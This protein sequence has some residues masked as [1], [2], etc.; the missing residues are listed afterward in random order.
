MTQTNKS[1]NTP[2]AVTNNVDS[3]EYTIGDKTSVV[4]IGASAGGLDALERFFANVPAQT[5]LAFV[6][7]QHLSPTF[8]SLMHELLARYTNLPIYR[9][10]D[11]MK[12]EP[13]AIYLIPPGQNMLLSNGHLLLNDQD[14]AVA[15]QLPIDIFFRS[16]AHDRGPNSVAVILSG[17]GS[18]GSRGIM[19]IN[20]AGGLIVV[21]SPESA[22]FDGMPRNAIAKEVVD[23]VAAPEKMPSLIMRRL[24][25]LATDAEIDSD[26]E[27]DLSIVSSNYVDG[28]FGT[29][30]KSELIAMF[31]LLRRQY[32]IDFSVYKPAT[33]IRRIERRMVVCKK[34]SL[35]A[36]VD[37]L[38]DNVEE[39]EI[40]YRDFLVEVTEFFR[41]K[42]AY[43]HLEGTVL[44]LIRE[45]KDDEVIRV[46][47]A[48]CATGEEAYSMAI[49]FDRCRKS[50]KKEVEIQIF[51]TDVHQG[52]LALA[53]KGV[54]SAESLTEL[55]PLDLEEYFD[56]HNGNYVVKKD[57][58][59]TVI[60]SP[61]NL[62]QDPPFTRLHLVSCRNVLIYLNVTSQEKVLSRFHFGL[63]SGGILFLGASEHMAS[64]ISEDF[65]TINS[66]WRI[67]RKERDSSRLYKQQSFN[68]SDIR[69][70]MA[71]RR[72]DRSRLEAR[73]DIYEALLEGSIPASLL[74]DDKAML[75]R[76]FGNANKY[77][78]MTGEASLNVLDII[79]SSL[80]VALRS[81]LHRAAIDKKVITYHDLRWKARTSEEE[82]VQL[83]IQPIETKSATGISFLISFL[84]NAPRDNSPRDN[85]SRDNAL[86]E[87][88]SAHHRQSLSPEPSPEIQKVQAD[89]KVTAPHEGDE[90]SDSIVTMPEDGGIEVEFLPTE[91]AA[92]HIS[93]LEQELQYTHEYLHTTV[94]ELETT[95]EELQ[96]ANEEL[97]A[98]NEEL[99]STNEEL[100]SVNEELY[101]V[102]LEHQQKIVELEQLNT[103]VRN[104]MQST[105]MPVIFLDGDRNIRSYS[106][107]AAQLFSLLR[108]DIGRPL[109]QIYLKI[110][111]LPEKLDA[112]AQAAIEDAVS[113][114]EEV[115]IFKK[116]YLM[117]V[118][119]YETQNNPVDGVVIT[120]Y[121][122][123]QLKAAQNEYAESEARF[124]TL[125]D[126]ANDA[127]IVCQRTGQISEVNA[128]ACNSLNYT[129]EE[130]LQMNMA[131]IE[132]AWS[133]ETFMDTLTQA[134]AE[135]G[136]YTFVGAHR[137]KNGTELTVESQVAQFTYDGEAD[138]LILSRDIS[139]R[140]EVENQIRHLNVELTNRAEHLR[141]A[142]DRLVKSNV[143]LD[144]FVEIAAHDL[145]EPL[146]GLQHYAQMM[147]HNLEDCEDDEVRV[148]LDA[149]QRLSIRMNNLIED[150]RIF[151]RIDKSESK[152]SNVDLNEVL[153]N[154]RDNL[155]ALLEESDVDIQVEAPLP[156][157]DYHR[158]HAT[159]IFQNLISN[160]IK[161]NNK[162][163]K[164]IKISQLTASQ[165]GEEEHTVPE[166]VDIENIAPDTTVYVIEDNGIGIP[167][168]HHTKVFEMFR[169][170]H[171]QD[172][173]GGGTGAGLAL[174]KKVIELYD[175]HIWFTS[176]PDE[177][178][179]FYLV[180]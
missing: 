163:H 84:P 137:R 35:A 37:F 170:L 31:S 21:Q 131:D 100:Q 42:Q 149:I 46:W 127:I 79:D 94:E 133:R 129:K 97:I 90:L 160:A 105:R 113:H 10:E 121:D 51:A 9:V 87:D 71:E 174:V 25:G 145:K 120:F 86:R 156:T 16:L 138:Y 108:Q 142:N 53:A 66:Q 49:L 106:D 20:Q 80:A 175:G 118:L 56:I 128:E 96:S 19:D 159:L 88:E 47:V 144:R 41:D 173:Y 150:L 11:S 4:G 178:T 112:L 33:I 36:Y 77:L 115:S 155:Y 52:S 82:S 5:N 67:F 172:A 139:Q 24:A 165:L 2:A 153:A 64:S 75:L 7:V 43:Q 22:G 179:T 48:G 54:Y 78:S 17:T 107:P 55:R 123:S 162:P 146:R 157:I 40:L 104:L 91:E 65:R 147:E 109:E 89:N 125:V 39:Q 1:T 152:E 13:D 72:I 30:R 151:G 27:E 154:V 143:E 34:N 73:N 132:Q 26:A 12:V 122:I 61:H 136:R 141:D 114:E 117:R 158:Q 119:P 83:R 44:T 171:V 69:P 6:I 116:P 58:R 92:N 60:F 8:K 29:F 140:A 93:L 176:E 99:Q 3:T 135:K 103:D 110:G 23:I 126:S 98:S 18:D 168:R 76:T 50:L 95:N 85:S 38:T 101:T 102:N 28:P 161:Y 134:V 32:Q 124:R 57:L 74:L 180:L 164:V 130:L 63:K 167:S 166:G 81:G 70:V 14:T 68:Y 59:K 148:C 177:G 15:P 169:R 45:A 62:I 111:L